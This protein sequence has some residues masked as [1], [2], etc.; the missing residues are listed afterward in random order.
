MTRGSSTLIGPVVGHPLERLLDDA[1]AL[2]HLFEAHHEAIEVVAVRADRHVEV[3]L[4]VL[5]VRVRLAHVV[6]DAGRAQHGPVQP[7]AMR[8]LAR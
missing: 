5:Q 7:S 2:A 1:R 8:V 4:V 6:G 3:D